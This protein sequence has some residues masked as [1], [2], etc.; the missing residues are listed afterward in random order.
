MRVIGDRTIFKYG[1]IIAFLRLFFKQ[2]IVKFLRKM[3][4]ENIQEN[5][6]TRRSEPEVF[7]KAL[8]L[9]K[10][11]MYSEALEILN[12]FHAT[13]A[14]DRR[15]C[16]EWRIS[17]A[18]LMGDL[19]LAEDILAATLD[20]GFFLSEFSLRHD[21]DLSALQGRPRFEQ[22]ADHNM[23]LMA[24]AQSTARPELL[25]VDPPVQAAAKAPLIVALHGNN[26]NAQIIKEYWLDLSSFGWRLAFPQSSQVSGPG[27]F[28]WNDIP[29]AEEE[30]KAHYAE[31]CKRSAVDPARTVISGFSKGGHA[32]LM[33]AFTQ[34]F[35]ISG[36]IGVAPYFG[37]VEEI[38][39]GLNVAANQQVRCYFLLGE[40]DV[41]CTAGALA[42]KEKLAAAGIAC[43]VEI[44]P[45][46]GH[47]FPADA[48][49]AIQR[50]LDFI[51][52]E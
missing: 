13:D 1:S 23:Q 47:D 36:Y 40:D 22:L 51:L 50:A 8:A 34:A 32:A 44:F 16:F 11:K 27:V 45:G 39:T 30:L 5:F 28:V 10:E 43:G 2:Q 18:T 25:L 46:V 21:E 17:M 52:S 4:I 7:A 9:Y 31:I 26:T 15:Q 37:Q 33:A 29:R 48:T 41:D 42:M 12:N 19:D 20:E 35:P 14:L 24:Q 49:S 38:F 6:M 3:L